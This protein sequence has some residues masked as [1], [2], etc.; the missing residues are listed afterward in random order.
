MPH[1][2]EAQTPRR[3]FRLHHRDSWPFAASAQQPAM[4]LIGFVRSCSPKKKPRHDAGL[5]TKGNPN[6][7]QL[8]NHLCQLN[9]ALLRPT[10]GCSVAR[11]NTHTRRVEC[12]ARMYG[13]SLTFAASSY[14]FEF[15]AIAQPCG[16]E[17]PHSARPAVRQ[18]HCGAEGKGGW[19]C[20]GA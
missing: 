20:S 18:C 4:P 7:V 11:T 15:I 5:R 10:K 9:A 3:P 12:R 19:L 16:R 17:Q 1:P 2:W 13:N 6:T 14:R 8:Q